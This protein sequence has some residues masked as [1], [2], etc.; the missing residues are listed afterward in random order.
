MIC[1]NPLVLRGNGNYWK[2]LPGTATSFNIALSTIQA[3]EPT[4]PVFNGVSLDAGNQATIYTTTAN[5]LYTVTGLDVGNGKLIGHKPNDTLVLIALWEPGIET[6][7]GSGVVPPARRMVFGAAYYAQYNINA[8]G[9]IVFLNAVNFMLGSKGLAG[10]P[11]PSSGAKDVSI[12]TNLSWKPGEYANTHNLFFGTDFDDV[13]DSTTTE[14]LGETVLSEGRAVDANTFDPGRLEYGKTYY[15]R[16]DEV[17]EPPDMTEYKGKVWS[18]TAEL[19]GYPLAASHISATAN[20]GVY[21]D[22]ETQDPNSTCNGS[23]LNANDTHSVDQKTMWLAMGEPGEAYIQYTFDQPYKLNDI[24]IWNYNEVAPTNAFGAKD[25]N[26]VYSLDGQ[27]WTQVGDTV[28]LDMAPGDANCAANAPIDLQGVAAK[29]VK[30]IFWSGYD[31]ETPAYGISE[32]RFSVIPTYAQLP[33]PADNATNQA[34]DSVMTWKAGRDVNDHYLYVSTDPNNLGSPNVLDDATFALTLVLNQTYYWRVDEV[35]NAEVYPVWDG[36]VWKFSTVSSRLIE[37]FETGYD[38]SDA[39]AVWATWLDGDGGKRPANGGSQMG[40]YDAPYLSAINHSGGHSSPMSF[41]NT[42]TFSFSQVVA[43]STDLPIGTSDWSLGSPKTL[44][45]WFRGDVNAVVVD[46]QLYCIIG[47]KTATYSGTIEKLKTDFWHQWDIDLAAL[48]VNLSNIPQIT[49]GI[50]KVGATGG[51][52]VIYLDDIQLTGIAPATPATEILIEGEAYK[53]LTA[54]MEVFEVLTG[55]SG[56]KYIG[57]ADGTGDVTTAP[58]ADGSGTATYTFTV[59]GGVYQLN[60]RVYG[61]NSSNSFWIQIPEIT[62]PNAVKTTTG[63]TVTT[64]NGWIN[65][66]N[67][68]G[69]A[70]WHWDIVLSANNS[71]QDVEWHLPAGTYT[72]KVACREDGFMLDAFVVTK[73]RDL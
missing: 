46:D 68:D 71:N 54:P 14:L 38:D 37:G 62:D 12:D 52:G 9:E 30:I 4:H 63:A 23:G 19:K 24:K 70:N 20:N 33:V 13:N 56:G 58:P 31:P 27:T 1:M 67:M 5:G 34:V 59:S 8:T 51:K 39:N 48:G 61:Y 47:G 18:F 44:T 53:T 28:T 42:G 6:Y 41:D 29:Y 11:N 7:T 21:T 57:K 49:I 50:K 17:N 55:A 66:N 73:V 72:L 43:Q 40:N 36:P 10:S 26:I 25:V 64:T 2:W 16:V 45:I 32:V 3:D 60:F 69:S 15:W 22:T 65:T 35:N